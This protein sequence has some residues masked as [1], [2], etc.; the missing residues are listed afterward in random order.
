METRAI[1]LKR[2]RAPSP[3]PPTSPNQSTK[4]PTKNR[5]Q[6]LASTENPVVLISPSSLGESNKGEVPRKKGTI[7][8]RKMPQDKISLSNQSKNLKC[9][10]ER[11]AKKAPKN[12]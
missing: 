7:K 2:V 10:T 9:T 6:A 11:P 1:G 8:D 3:S 12:K 4:I 5:Y